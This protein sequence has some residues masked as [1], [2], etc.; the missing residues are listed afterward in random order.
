M[1]AI[2]HKKTI[3]TTKM[4]DKVWKLVSKYIRMKERGVCFTC[5]NR[6]HW[7]EQNCGH[8]IHQA[9]TS[10][11]AFCEDILHC[12]CVKCNKYM[13]GNLLEYTTKM[14]KI[15]G[16]QQVETWKR[17][18]SKPYNW[19]VSELETLIEKYKELNKKLSEKYGDI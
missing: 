1:T 3:S 13:S 11:L 17:E 16:L 14:V 10:K 6:R 8:F 12:Q 19:K 9:K 4:R 5:G 15:Y 18:S 2:K 7:K